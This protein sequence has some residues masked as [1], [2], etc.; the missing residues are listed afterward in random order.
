MRSVTMSKELLEAIDADEAKVVVMEA[1]D[2]AGVLA[3]ATPWPWDDKVVA[4]AK[5]L[6]NRP[7]VWK[8]VIGLINR[9]LPEDAPE[10]VV[11]PELQAAIADAAPGIDPVTIA[12]FITWALP[13]IKKAIEAW[14]RR[15]QGPAPSPTPAVA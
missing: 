1:L 7:L 15:R 14:K 2:F 5:N 4:T 10:A 8:V 3:A 11:D 13:L 6:V 12:A 9:A